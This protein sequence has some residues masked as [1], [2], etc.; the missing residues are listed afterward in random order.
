MYLVSFVTENLKKIGGVIL[1]L[2]F[3][4]IRQEFQNLTLKR[5]EW[6]K[7]IWALDIMIEI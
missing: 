3:L 4:V 6:R 5:E 1:V 2:C 7:S